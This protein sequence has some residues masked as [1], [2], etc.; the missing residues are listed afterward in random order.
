[1][2]GAKYFAILT[3]IYSESVTKLLPN[4]KEWMIL[5]GQANTARGLMMQTLEL[6]AP[7]LKI[8]I[9]DI[10]SRVFIV[11]T[12]ETLYSKVRFKF[13]PWNIRI[14]TGTSGS[15]ILPSYRNQPHDSI[16]LVP[17][18]NEKDRGKV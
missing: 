6:K 18:I 8:Y 4:L 14:A 15:S 9:M 11:L 17:S 2:L 12:Q 7:T 13:Q 10:I 16:A 3:S 5:L 1:M